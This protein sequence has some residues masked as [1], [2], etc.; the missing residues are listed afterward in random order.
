MYE[1]PS[2]TPTLTRALTLTEFL[3]SKRPGT[4][5]EILC[6]LAFH[7]RYNASQEGLTLSMVRQQLRMLPYKII[8]I[9]AA[10]Q[11]ASEKLG[12]LRNKPDIAEDIF[13]LTEAGLNIVKQLP[14][15]PD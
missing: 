4:E 6:C 1:T 2:P 14:R 11:E 15:T 9:P 7:Q 5:A 13:E 12:Y 8:N 3:L 10:L